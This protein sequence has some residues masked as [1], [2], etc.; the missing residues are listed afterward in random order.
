MKYISESL[1][2]VKITIADLEELKTISEQTFID[3]YGIYNTP[4]NLKSYLAASYNL[5]QL[6]TEINNDNCEYYFAKYEG[7]TAGYIK[8]N[9]GDAQTELQDESSIEIERIYL[10]K[11]YQ[12]KKIGHRFIDFTI[13]RAEKDDFQYI[14]LGVWEQNPKAIE[15]YHKTGFHQFDTHVFTLGDE[16]QTDLLMKLE[17]SRS[18]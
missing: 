9:F 8:L 18:L 10:S 15:F 17:I 4:E 2:I 14:W 13:N 11:G 16:E 12:G 5:E 7:K 3:T 1:E 6:T